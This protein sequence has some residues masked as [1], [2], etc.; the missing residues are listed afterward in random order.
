MPRVNL[1]TQVIPKYV[2]VKT[3]QEQ[4]RL[5]KAEAYKLL[6]MPEFQEAIFKIGER[7]IRVDIELA[8]KI[9]K[10]LFN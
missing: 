5:S 8:H 7:G 3:F 10:Q 9:L 1:G 4:Y 2:P 6:K